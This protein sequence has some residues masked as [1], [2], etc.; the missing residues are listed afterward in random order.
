[1]DENDAKP[2]PESKPESA[3]GA[4]SMLIVFGLAMAVILTALITVVPN[5]NEIF[6]SLD[7]ALPVP[8]ALTL[9]VANA[10][11]KYWFIVLPLLGLLTAAPM[12]VARRRARRIYLVATLVALVLAF[13]AFASIHLPIVKIQQMLNKK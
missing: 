3:P 5:F 7:V 2:A 1:M 6:K 9:L 8:T 12:I 11:Q 4:L 10:C 13:G